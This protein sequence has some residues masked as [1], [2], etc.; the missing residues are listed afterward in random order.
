MLAVENVGVA[1]GAAQVIWNLSL[2]VEKGQITCLM[3][4]NGVGKST[5]LRGIIGHQAI[6]GGRIVWQGKDVSKL[7]P[8]ERARM[9]IAYVP[10]GREIFPL[11]SVKENLESDYAALGGPE[12]DDSR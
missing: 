6:W 5:L 7:A 4:C 10:Q 2:S 3:G 8:F 11:L 1:Y 9:G 12:A